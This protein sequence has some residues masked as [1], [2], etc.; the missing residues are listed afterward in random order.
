MTYH[1]CG[2][3]FAPNVGHDGLRCGLF[4]EA[5]PIILRMRKTRV[6]GMMGSE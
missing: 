6:A 4:V 2:K 5:K 3:G 1:I